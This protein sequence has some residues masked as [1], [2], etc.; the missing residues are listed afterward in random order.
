MKTVIV[1]KWARNPEDAAVRADGTVDWRN[2]RMT[3]GEDDFAALEAARA[4]A[5]EGEL[6]GLTIGDGDASWALARGVLQ[7]VAVT[8]AA[9]LADN[10]A[11]AAIIAAAIRRIGGVDAVVIGDSE[12][13]SGVPVALAGLLG[14]PAVA[15]ATSAEAAGGRI[16]V[17]RKQGRN[18][19]TISLATPAVIS[20]AAASPEKK[21]PGM[22]E[23]LAAR[24][25]PITRQTLADIDAAGP[26]GVTT[27]GTRLPDGAAARLFD[28][29]PA[30]A[31]R[32]LVAALRDEGVL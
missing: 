13:Y 24:K 18:D 14:W 6:I 9:P 23:L 21:V 29:D 31:A 30:N 3:A 7:A 16:R 15:H 10:A 17:V 11:T 2:A 26:D 25:R 20:I 5:P 12:E 4:I 22:K 27:K 28:G 19:Q 32:Q 1:Y 8:D